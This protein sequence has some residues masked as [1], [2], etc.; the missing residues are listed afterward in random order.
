MEAGSRL[1]LS[2]F[3][4]Y[5]EGTLLL[6]LSL[7]TVRTYDWERR[8]IENPGV[9]VMFF[10]YSWQGVEKTFKGVHLFKFYCIFLG[11][12][13]GGFCFIPPSP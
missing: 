6:P 3:G 4:I 2:P 5:K 12:F 7:L 13:P 1:P 10:K 8:W 11:N 9:G